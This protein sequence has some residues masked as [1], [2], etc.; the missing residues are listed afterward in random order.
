MALPMYVIERSEVCNLT[1]DNTIDS[2]SD[3]FESVASNLEENTS[4]AL[5]WLKHSNMFHEKSDN[6][7][8]KFK[9]SVNV[10]SNKKLLMVT[11]VYLF[12]SASYGFPA[13]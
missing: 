7:N 13:K 2:C 5:S 3:T 8:L 12:M 1:N 10:T 11:I 9:E 6:Y 4:Q